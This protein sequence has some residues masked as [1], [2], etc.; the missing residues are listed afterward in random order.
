MEEA[1]F[2]DWRF[3]ALSPLPGWALGLLAVMA[4]GAVFA[5]WRGLSTERSPQRRR[6]LILLRAV[7]A[8]LAVA[9]LLEP[10]MEL[11]ATTRIRAR[12]AVL[13]DRSRSMRL[14]SFAGGPGR[15]AIA[16]EVLSDAE[17]RKA[18]ESRFQVDYYGFGQ[19]P[20]PGDAATLAAE[21]AGNGPPPDEPGLDH[22]YLLPALEEAAKAGGARPLAG[23]VLLTDGADN[24][25]LS[26]AL[27]QADESMR[28]GL[29]DRLEA[30]G[31]PIVALDVTEGELQDLSISAVRVDDFAFVRSKVEI[32]VELSQYGFGPLDVPLV[33]EREGQPVTSAQVSV[34]AEEPAKVKLSFTPDTTGEFAYQLRVPVQEGEAV[35]ANNTK[36]FV[37][38]VIRDRVRVLHV[39]GRPSWDERFLRLLLK[40]DANVDLISFFILRTPSDLTMTASNDELSLIP[41][42]TDEIFRQQL[43]SFD[44]VIFHNFTYQ[45]YH[46]AQ[47]LPG[48]AAYVKDGGSV[49]MLGG[50]Q[51]FSEG[52]YASTPLAEVLPV[53]L[54]NAPSPV[55]ETPFQG[56]LT[57]EGRRHPVTELAPGEAAN[58]EA[59]RAL[60]PL[61]GIN[62]TT[63]KPGAT[64]LLEHPQMNDDTGRP[65][66]V[67]AVMEAGRGRS[68]AVTADSTWLWSFQA[69]KQGRP[70][71]AY[72][73]FFR[74]AIRWLVRDPELTQ[75]RVQAERER[76]AP[77]DAVSLNVKARSRDYGPADG[78][79][80]EVEVRP[81]AGGG[82]RQ[83]KGVVGAEGTARLEVGLLGP[84][85]Y[86]AT[87]VARRDGEE[88]GRA[89][90]VFVV[91]EGGV[92]LS[93]PGPRRDLMA[94]LAEATGGKLMPAR[95]VKLD[96]LPIKDPEKVEIGQRKSRPLW[97][98]LPILLLLCGLLGSEWFLR[99]RWGYA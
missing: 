86:R 15:S 59:W 74:H 9:L 93:R 24:G 3:V 75:V 25:V 67:V 55:V 2:N 8:L 10:G 40:R 98:R 18:F 99:R 42:P 13:L 20:S 14:P 68:M 26:E 66:P 41:F 7:A 83:I 73:E 58:D 5:A 89:E 54:T 76:F 29:K 17:S 6:V 70:P 33:L 38:K 91:E 81:A 48:I 27:A 30:L 11:L 77:S 12:V 61:H 34:S 78:A 94:W 19:A 69:A 88:L 57:A 84:G 1:V 46:M 65:A 80:I 62:R 31:A 49:L 47:Y 43:K 63:L 44:L 87:A 28:D 52:G 37:L 72:E 92:E 39:T 53:E 51:S 50:E 22:T 45:P 79:R 32:E 71:R 23:L 90:D 97:D 60:A 64:A 56:R 16:G 96:E 4:A 85:A 82:S 95:G 35:T 21:S 36:A